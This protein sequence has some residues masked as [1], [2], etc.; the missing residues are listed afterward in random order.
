VTD[1]VDAGVRVEALPT[2]DLG[3]S[4]PSEDAWRAALDP[5]PASTFDDVA[6]R[7]LVVIAPH[8]DDESLGA[9]GTI[10]MLS[11]A[12]ARVHVVCLTN[13]EAAPCATPDLAAVRQRELVSAIAILAPQAEI[14]FVGLPDGGLG[15]H[16]DLLRE[17]LGRLIGA[18]DLVLATL[19]GDGHPDH[20]AAGAAAADVARANGAELHW[21]AVWA[22]HWHDPRTSPLSRRGRR[23][24][25]TAAAATRRNAAIAEHRSQLDGS[26]AVVPAEHV[27]RCRRP[28]EVLICAVPRQPRPGGP[29]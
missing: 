22:W 1:T 14:T 27:Q 25:L 15:A 24:E 13:G 3:R 5:L 28:Y 7:R 16:R 23:S 26:S 19:A 8:P 12:G 10:A 18:D 20:D 17:R 29:R 2:I 4:G 21:F 9:G 11:D 6:G